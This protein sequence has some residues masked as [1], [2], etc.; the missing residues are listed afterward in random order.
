M[1][2]RRC[3]TGAASWRYAGRW[4]CFAPTCRSRS[5]YSAPQALQQSSTSSDVCQP[6]QATTRFHQLR[7]HLERRQALSRRRSKLRL[8]PAQAVWSARCAIEKHR[9]SVLMKLYNPFARCRCRTVPASKGAATSC[10]RRRLGCRAA[11][12]WARRR[13]GGRAEA[14][15]TP[16]RLQPR[17]AVRVAVAL[18]G[19]DAIAS[20]L[21][22]NDGSHEGMLPVFAS[23]AA[24]D[25]LL[26]VQ[27]SL[28]PS[29][30][31]AP[32]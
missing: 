2:A 7:Q 29:F 18:R 24:C 27:C 5:P 15:S 20:Q 22:S 9:F 21:L 3:R 16:W 4:P 11:C 12:A 30:S 10:C 14:S 13:R 32:Y 26:K 8:F 17:C 25:L 23:T 6:R 31:F 28:Q 19:C 1:F